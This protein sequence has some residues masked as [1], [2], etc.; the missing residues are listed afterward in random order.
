MNSEHYN[1]SAITDFFLI[2]GDLL[3]QRIFI[4]LNYGILPQSRNSST[5][6]EFFHN[7][8]FSSFSVVYLKSD[9]S[10]GQGSAIRI[11]LGP[12]VF[13]VWWTILDRVPAFH[14][15]VMCFCFYVKRLDSTWQFHSRKPCSLQ[16]WLWSM[17]PPGNPISW[18]CPVW[19]RCLS[20]WRGSR[21]S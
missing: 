20:W 1:S 14:Q 3:Q 13:R 15:Q 5:I 7:C 17:N 12:V 4:F 21:E 6:T 11:Q 19:D 16:F 8:G 9:W 10:S 18:R 2:S